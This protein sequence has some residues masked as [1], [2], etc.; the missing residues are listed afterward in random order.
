MFA[1]LTSQVK[2]AKDRAGQSWRYVKNQFK[3]GYLSDRW[4]M[5]WAYQ[6][7]MKI[8]SRLPA[9]FK[10][11]YELQVKPSDLT[12]LP[13]EK[14][15]TPRALLIAPNNWAGQA[16]QWAGAA[17][18]LPDTTGL[19]IQYDH[20][21]HLEYPAAAKFKKDIVDRSILWS[22][23][24]D[25]WVRDNLTHVI[26]ESGRP[27]LGNLYRNDLR[28]EILALQKQGIRVGLLWHGTDIRSPHQHMEREPNSYFKRF[29]EEEQERR[30]ALVQA[31]KD[32]VEG[33]N[34]TEF[35]STPGLIPYRPGAIWLPQLVDR[36]KWVAPTSS[37]IVAR[38]APLVI[39]VPS[40]PLVK[41]TDQI[42]ETA[43]KLE[44]EGVITFKTVT[45]VHASQMPSV[46]SEADIVI[47]QMGDP[48][49][50]S[51]AIEAMQLGKVVLG[52][53]GEEVPQVVREGFAVELPVV[54]IT[55]STLEQTLRDLAGDTQRRRQLSAKGIDFVA[56]VHTV[57]RVAGILDKDFLS[58]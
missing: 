9:R 31:T 53:V 8:N 20:G 2:S 46:I 23:R 34:L 13:K 19:N 24:L 18:S 58:Q 57:P 54:N 25:R 7:G 41:G 22:K 3:Y 4:Y 47:D 50:G 21:S 33:L 48:N 15:G 16:A 30:E 6:A 14:L 28:E 32:R 27:F 1:K 37:E 29:P 42:V 40:Q 51:A 38:E 56:Q 55:P 43:K 26:V 35:I 5:P 44:E 45:G 36:E 17:S 52:E 39:Y 49:Y 11:R 12:A 10:E